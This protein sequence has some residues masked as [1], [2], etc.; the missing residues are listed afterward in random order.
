MKTHDLPSDATQGPYSSKSYDM[1]ASGL[2]EMV[3]STNLRPTI[4]RNLYENTGIDSA[5]YFTL[6]YWFAYNWA[7]SLLASV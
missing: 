6:P 1:H 2:V 4:Y 5:F 7:L 3:I